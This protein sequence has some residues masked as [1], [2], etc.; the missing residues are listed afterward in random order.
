MLVFLLGGEYGGTR[1]SVL[2]L[3]C[4]AWQTGWQPSSWLMSKGHILCL[5]WKW[6]RSE[7]ERAALTS[8]EGILVKSQSML[9]GSRRG[10][11]FPT[12]MSKVDGAWRLSVL[13]RIAICIDLKSFEWL[14]RAIGC[15]WRA[16]GWWGWPCCCWTP[17]HCKSLHLFLTGCSNSI[18]DKIRSADL[19]AVSA[20]HSFLTASSPFFKILEQKYFR[21]MARWDTVSII[22]VKCT[23]DGKANFCIRR[24]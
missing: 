3:L 21:G 12:Q 5:M 22:G 13:G 19:W 8:K 16:A 18:P 4:L 2:V 6:S 10:E 11:L 15:E 24:I 23:T 1:L 17:L 7:G 9:E 14:Q 20:S